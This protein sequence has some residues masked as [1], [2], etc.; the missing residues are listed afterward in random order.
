MSWLR[1]K[2]LVASTSANNNK[3]LGLNSGNTVVAVTAEDMVEKA[4]SSSTTVQNA[5]NTQTANAI[6]NDNSVQQVFNNQVG[7]AIQNDNSVNNV[8]NSQVTNAINN[9]PGTQAAMTTQVTNVNNNPT[10]TVT[11]NNPPQVNGQPVLAL[12]TSKNDG[13]HLMYDGLGTTDVSAKKLLVKASAAEKTQLVNFGQTSSSVRT[14]QSFLRI[15]NEFYRFSFLDGKNHGGRT[16]NHSGNILNEEQ[17]WTINSSTNEITQSIN[18]RGTIGFAS[19]AGEEYDSY[20]AIVQFKSTG[21]DNDTIGWVVSLNRGA[22][23]DINADTPSDHSLVIERDLNQ[24][25]GLLL[26]IRRGDGANS[27][28]QSNK[29]RFPFGASSS[30]GGNWPNYNGCPIKVERRPDH[31]RV[32]GIDNTS[33]TPGWDDTAWGTP[34]FDLALSAGNGLAEFAQPGNWGLC[35]RSQ[36]LCSWGDLFFNG[37]NEGGLELSPQPDPITNNLVFD[38]ESGNTYKYTNGQWIVDP[39]SRTIHDYVDS[40]QLLYDTSSKG[41]YVKDNGE[42]QLL[43]SSRMNGVVL[44]ANSGITVNDIGKLIVAGPGCNVLTFNGNYG[45]GWN[46]VILNKSNAS[47]KI[48]TGGASGAGSRFGDRGLAQGNTYIMLDNGGEARCYGNGHNAGANIHVAMTGGD[49]GI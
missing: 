2:D 8:F 31:L 16:S 6:Q 20:D 3:M 34:I 9:D 11:Y 17:S 35:A 47:L 32:W 23:N 33:T 25:S 45:L 30:N 27:T 18:S 12:P 26:G 36:G 39:Q 38:I 14:A 44:T 10:T 5:F 49:Y 37:V 42:L 24:G 22:P 40:G 21:Q 4:I 29:A 7:D 15:L 13:D 46:C 48:D 1:L 19:P 43:Q 28:I 41:L